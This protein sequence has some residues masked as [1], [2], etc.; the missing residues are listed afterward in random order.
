MLD[1]SRQRCI[2]GN[3]KDANLI[4]WHA[5]DDHTKD[6]SKLPHPADAR[7]WKHYDSMYPEFCDEPRNVRL[8]LSIDE[9]NPFRDLSSSHNT[10]LVIL[11]IYNIPPYLCLKHK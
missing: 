11:T 2:F 6:D 9:M 7:Q 5:S 10:C 4:S 1:I 3:P 8:A